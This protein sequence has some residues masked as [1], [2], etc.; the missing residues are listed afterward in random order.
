MHTA[1][2]RGT[3]LPLSHI[4]KGTRSRVTLASFEVTSGSSSQPC[5][6]L[7]LPPQANF[8]SYNLE[9]SGLGWGGQEKPVEGLGCLDSNSGLFGFVH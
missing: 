3:H 8:T 7:S 2:L 6:L 1:P 4:T 9:R 5:K